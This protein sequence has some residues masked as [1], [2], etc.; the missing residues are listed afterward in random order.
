MARIPLL[1]G[2]YSARGVIANAQRCV[3]LYPEVGQE[4]AS[5]YQQQGNAQSP[6]PVAHYQCPGTVLLGQVVGS[7]DGWRGLYEASNGALYG[8]NGDGVYYIPNTWVPQLLGIIQRAGTYPNQPLVSFTDNG[9][10]VMFAD[11]GPEGYS[12]NLATNVMTTLNAATNGDSLGYGFV[13]A[14]MVDYLD[15]FVIGTIPGTNQFFSSLSNELVFEPLQVASK[16]GFPDPLQGL[17]VAQRNIWLIGTQT[18]EVWANTGDPLFPFTII[19]NAYVEHGCEAVSSIVKAEESVLWLSKDRRGAP[20]VLRTSGYSVQKVSTF[21]IE[22]EW[23]T[24]PKLDDAVAFAYQQEGHVFYRI[25]FPSA[26]DGKGATWAYDLATSQW[27]E[28]LYMLPTDNDLYRHRGN[29]HAYAYGVNVVGDYQNGNLYH[30]DLDT[31]TDN[32]TPMRFIRGFPHLVD[33]LDR[34]VYPSFTADMQ[35]GEPEPNGENVIPEPAC[36]LAVTMTN[37]NT[38]VTSG[39]LNGV[40]PNFPCW[41]FVGWFF[42]QDDGAEHGVWFGNQDSDAAPGNGGLQIGIFNDANSAA[43]QQI[44]VKCYD[45]LNAIIVSATYAW[46]SWNQWVLVMASCDTT[47]QTLQVVVNDTTGFHTLTPSAI[48]WSSTNPVGNPSG[49]NW[50]VVV[51][52]P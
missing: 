19:T 14:G 37:S 17:C 16:T 1:S 5:I 31:H 39:R 21:A 10:D 20:R 26:R 36:S 33:D 42:Q 49:H 9:I 7:T 22:N 28:P 18:S 2:A 50:H 41:L 4:Q 27:H 13:G 24:Y 51:P 8:V 38:L 6:T 35:A 25:T 11:G 52:A 47:T 15:S 3:N 48:T 46:T 44:V 32:G 23:N 40:G 45:Q 30:L 43:G 12:I 29:C 34:V